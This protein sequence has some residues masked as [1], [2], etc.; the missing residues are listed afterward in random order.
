MPDDS[1]PITL[2]LVRDDFICALAGPKARVWKGTKEL[3]T[4]KGRTETLLANISFLT[5]DF[6]S[7]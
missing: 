4:L 5:L 1:P 6:T 2:L 3:V 7:V